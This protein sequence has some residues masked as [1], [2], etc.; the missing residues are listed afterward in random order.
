MEKIALP[1]SELTLTQKLDLLEALW[2]DL[3]RQ[4]A[5]FESP[6]WHEEVLK[7]REQALARGELSFTDW[8]ESKERIRGRLK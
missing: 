4:G 6:A 5:A 8:E 3:S 1:L 7:D 2:E